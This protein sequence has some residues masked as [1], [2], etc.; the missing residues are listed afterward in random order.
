MLKTYPGAR[1]RGRLV[2]FTNGMSANERTGFLSNWERT[3]LGAV[4]LADPTRQVVTL[5]NNRYDRVARSAVFAKI[6]VE[7]AA[8]DAHI[9]IGTNLRGLE[10]Y[11]DEALAAHVAAF[12]VLRAEELAARDPAPAMARL[13]RL[14]AQLRIPVPDP[15]AVVR[16]LETYAAGAPSSS[17]RRSAPRAPLR[18]HAHDP[19]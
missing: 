5:V 3:E 18:D 11:L 19:R 7:D 1:V 17:P 8:A 14:F 4:D 12:E 13:A 9:L 2:E 15:E 16:R 6:L 10:T